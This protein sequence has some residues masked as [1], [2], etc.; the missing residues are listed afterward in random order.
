M[1]T[2]HKKEF[3]LDDFSCEHLFNDEKLK[4]IIEWLNDY[5]DIYLN[6]D[7]NKPWISDDTKKPVTKKDVW[8]QLI[9]LL[10]SSY[11]QMRTWTGS[12]ENLRNMYH[13]R[14]NHKL[15]EWHQFCDWVETLPYAKELIIGEE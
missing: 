7:D 11:N 2:I 1:H 6:W 3:T 12:Y 8:W 10:P 15:D 5:R 9:Q 13:Q 14:K 4:T